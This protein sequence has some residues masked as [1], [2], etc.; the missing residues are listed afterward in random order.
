LSL[1]YW[2]DNYA[3]VDNPK[4]PDPSRRRLPLKLWPRQLQLAEFL[5]EGFR[6][7][8]KRL[9]NKSREVGATWLAAHII[10]WLWWTEP[11][12]SALILS[13]KE[14]LVDDRTPKS[15]FGKLRF[16]LDCQPA[17]LRPR[18]GDFHMR[19]QNLDNSSV[20]LGDSTSSNVGRST[21]HSIVLADEWAHVPRANQQPIKIALES[22]ARSWW[23]ISTPSGRGDEFHTD[24]LL[25]RAEDK[26][27]LGWRTDPRRNEEWFDGLLRENGGHLTWDERAQEY[28]CSFAGVSGHRILRVDPKRL[29]Y[30][31]GDLPSDA[32]N[33]WPVVGGMDFGS[34]PSLTVC[35]F[36]VIEWSDD[37]KEAPTVWVDSELYWQR[38]PASEIGREILAHL[39]LYAGSTWIVGDPAGRQKESDQESW[40]SNLRAAG[41]PVHCLEPWFNQ[42]DAISETLTNLE[43][44]ASRG[45]LRIHERCQYLLECLESW[46]WDLPPG[47]PLELANKE[48]IRPRKDTW[49]HGGDALRYLV[50][51]VLR[52]PRPGQRLQSIDLEALLES[53]PQTPS[54]RISDMHRRVM[55]RW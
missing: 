5:H 13:A 22:V 25:S 21:R 26:L 19:L 32:R 30:A 50:G 18:V 3:Y 40:E 43:Q 17:F 7:G 29:I 9:V 20:V 38:R 1:F 4:D 6:S 16:I 53:L 8:R 39:R 51:A 42:A 14:K 47:L 44:L 33:K 24:W 15:V 34:G 31:E 36:A 2:L 48:T 10:Y 23:K 54:R 35:A 52:S 41:A 46:T 45:K 55:G 28:D 27:E 12:F 37:G 49:S 11:D